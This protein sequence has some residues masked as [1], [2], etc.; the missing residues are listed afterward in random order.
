MPS[1]VVVGG[2]RGI[3]LALVQQLAS[4]AENTVFATVRNKSGSTYLNDFVA[5]STLHNIHVLE[6]DVTD[7][8]A[9]KAAAT[10]VAKVTG[11]SLDVLIHN[12]ARMEMANGLRGPTDFE[13]DDTLDA[14]FLD[15]FKVNVLGAIHAVNAFLPLLRKGTTKKIAVI[16][17]EGGTSE[18]VWKMR[19][20]GLA[21]YGTTKAAEHLV[22]LKYAALL[23][24]EGFTVMTICPGFV[25]TSGT[26]VEKLT[27]ADLSKL[28][29][30]VTRLQAICTDFHP[31]TPEESVKRLLDLVDSANIKENGSFIQC[32]K[33]KED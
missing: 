5:K 18:F 20:S 16:G 14:E 22:V 6:A 30:I 19:L 32:F 10:D 25:D 13:D 33:Y 26:A 31:V 29:G 4:S 8:R 3:G 1:Y 27:D 11:G 21:A 23:E 7:H 15:S 24:P 2:S 9:L 28:T 12:A 17:T